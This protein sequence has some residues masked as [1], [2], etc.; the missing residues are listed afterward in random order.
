MDKNL[1]SS[2][3]SVFASGIGKMEQSFRQNHQNM[4]PPD[5]AI[6]QAT[7]FSVRNGY[8]DQ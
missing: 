8:T 1:T 7:S 2:I 3:A 4:P 5:F 6:R